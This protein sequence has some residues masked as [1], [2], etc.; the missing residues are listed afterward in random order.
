MGEKLP[1]L[2]PPTLI[3]W[4]ENDRILD[5]PDAHKFHKALPGSRLVWIQNCGHVPHLE[6]PQVTAGAIEQFAGG[7]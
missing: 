1:A 4:G 5:P 7:D 6:K 3:L 2:S